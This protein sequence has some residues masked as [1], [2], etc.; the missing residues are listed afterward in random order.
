DWEVAA[1]LYDYAKDRK[2]QN[3]AG[4]LADGN[5]TGWNTLA[6][7]G[8]W[9]PDGTNGAHLMDFGFQRDSY[10]LAY[11]T[12]NAV[13][14]WIDGPAGTVVSDVGG[15]TRLQSLYAQDSWAFAPRWK[16][17]LGGRAEWWTTFNGFTR[18]PGAAP[19]VDSQWP[20]RK[21]SYF[22]PKAALS[23]QWL[24]DTVLKASAGRAVRFPTVGELYGATST[25]NSQYINDPN[26]KPEKSWTSE[27]SAEKDL[28]NGLL[29]L[30]FF[31]ENTR[32]ALYSQTTFDT[33]ANRNVSRVQNVGRIRTQ[34]LELA[35]NGND[36]LAK[37]LDLGASITYADS[38]I[39]ENAGFVARP[40]DTIGKQQ[41]NI[42]KWR[43][44]AL[45]S[46]RWDARWTTSV[47]ARYSGPQFRTL[48]NSDVNGDT[49][50]GVSKF[51]TADLRVRYQLN[52]NV[53]AAF[54]IDNLN[55][56]KFW[57]FHPYPQRSYVAELQMAI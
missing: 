23:W 30:T 17:V 46:Y 11:L 49:Y 15:M 56:D 40:G 31:T 37:G 42:A 57:N 35:Y 9:R 16:A 8:I 29:R 52:K 33:L 7:K 1:S 54:G 14:S 36:V 5:G 48:D 39:K 13:G 41:P 20:Q 22:S 28:G 18:I 55:N 25:V 51:F 10:Q 38:V 47:G 53:N 2:R 34:G 26:L 21:E 3:G 32:D 27:L 12:S 6:L 44:T 45:L 19:A 4:T 43:A 24:P 50:Q